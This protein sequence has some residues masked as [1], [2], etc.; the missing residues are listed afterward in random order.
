[1]E[2]EEQMERRSFRGRTGMEVIPNVKDFLLLL[3]F[4]LLL[5]QSSAGRE[6]GSCL[7]S[8]RLLLL[9]LLEQDGRLG[10]PALKGM[11]ADV[12][13]IHSAVCKTKPGHF[14]TSTIHFPTCEGVIKVSEQANE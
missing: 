12:D 7:L 14:E 6:T 3:L 5:P 2:V 9:Q 8:F 1:M 13:A 11:G 10:N 4:L